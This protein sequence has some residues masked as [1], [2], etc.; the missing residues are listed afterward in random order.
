MAP[1]EACVGPNTYRDGRAGL[2]RR[3]PRGGNTC[4]TR[5]AQVA[6]QADT[7]RLARLLRR[8]ACC[9]VSR[10]ATFHALRSYIYSSAVRLM[11][12][13]PPADLP[14]AYPYLAFTRKTTNLPLCGRTHLFTAKSFHKRTYTGRDVHGTR[15]TYRRLNPIAWCTL[16]TRDYP[17]H[18]SPTTHP[19][20]SAGFV[21]LA[22]DPAGLTLLREVAG[23][24]WAGIHSFNFNLSNLDAHAVSRSLGSDSVF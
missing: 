11:C 2:T 9:A 14:S 5:D 4:A 15:T 16:L 17:P 10:V 6:R 18:P 23:G 7:T 19:Q 1:V 20:M 24:W 8:F 12:P 22:A 3:G 21:P 13:G